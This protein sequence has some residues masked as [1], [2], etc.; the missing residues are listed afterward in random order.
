[1]AIAQAEGNLPEQGYN[2]QLEKEAVRFSEE[3]P[4]LTSAIRQVMNAL[5]N[6]GI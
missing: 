1:M 6:M 2:E 4:A 3:H 5:S